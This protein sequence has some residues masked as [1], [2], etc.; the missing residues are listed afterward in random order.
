M[1]PY[2]TWMGK[3]RD[4]RKEFKQNF[5]LFMVELRSVQTIGI[6]YTELKIKDFG[7]NSEIERILALTKS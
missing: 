7:G 5:L 1:L 4:S 3:V 2:L 6:P